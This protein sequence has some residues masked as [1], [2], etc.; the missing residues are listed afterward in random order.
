MGFHYEI[1]VLSEKWE[2]HLEVQ[3]ETAMGGF[4][5]ARVRLMSGEVYLVVV[6]QW[7]YVDYVEGFEDVPFGEEDIEDIGVTHEA[8]NIEA[9]SKRGDQLMKKKV[10]IY[11]EQSIPVDDA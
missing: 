8:I 5:V 9:L 4:Q 7:K 11:P 10:D 6:R 3:G 1:L 2:K